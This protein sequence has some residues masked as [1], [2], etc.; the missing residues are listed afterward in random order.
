MM[1]RRDFVRTI[2]T[3]A[4]GLAAASTVPAA[5]MA[6]GAGSVPDRPNIVFVFID[7]LGYGDLSLYR[8]TGDSGPE[9]E[10]LDR[11]AREGLHF[12]QFYASS[13]ICSPSRVG[14]MTGQYPQR[15]HVYGH[16]ASRERNRERGMAHWLSPDAVVLPRLLKDAGYA[17]AHYG[18][19]HLGG[20]R[21]VGNAPLPEDYGF[22]DALV[23]MEGLGERILEPDGEGLGSRSLG[24][25]EAIRDVPKHDMTEVWVDRAIAFAREHRDRP[26]Y[27][28]L[29]PR[30][31]H[32]PFK[33]SEAERARVEVP[34]GVPNPDQWRRFFAVLEEMDRQLGRFAD[35]LDEMGLG[36]DTMIVV[37]GDNGPTAWS[38]YYEG[39]KGEG[40]APGYTAGLRGRKWSL[41]EGGVREPFFVRWPGR[42][43]PGTRNERTVV[44]G[45][46]L[47]PSLASI[48]G[49]EL[50][51]A[52][53]S[54]GVD[55]SRALIGASRPVRARSIF[56]EYN[57]LGGNLQ[58]GLERDRSPTLAMRD[59]SWKV[60][61]NA[62]GSGRE[63][64]NLASDRDESE[65]LTDRFPR[66]TARMKRAL[67]R[68]YH[69]DLPVPRHGVEKPSPP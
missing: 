42:V 41:Y 32:D 23:S 46:D 36:P 18:K 19:W 67:L 34:E 63:L 47:L 58:P 28:N 33:P 39:D 44:T 4:V 20:Q 49:V 21:D 11:L 7:D 53:R 10:H 56:W 25:P 69:Q 45:V 22:D 26:F 3:G 48:A 27:L 16:L 17:T 38:R 57:A 43:P 14:V 61:A 59:G 2:G 62:D 52:Y 55:L 37:T 66:R 31:V 12:E 5:G 29:W 35:A 40:A 30:D 54:D 60:L 24:P 64:Y 6:G 8:R 68:W 13:P 9:T 15:W 65:N 51:S 50:P 1:N